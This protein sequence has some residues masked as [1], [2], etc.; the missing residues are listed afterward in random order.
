[1]MAG[2]A[3]FV[4]SKF[5][6]TALRTSLRANVRPA[7]TRRAGQGREGI[8]AGI[9]IDEFQKL[10]CHRILFVFRVLEPLQSGNGLPSITGHG[11]RESS[12]K[13]ARTSIRTRGT[14]SCRRSSIFFCTSSKKSALHNKIRQVLVGK[15]VTR[16]KIGS[17]DRVLYLCVFGKVCHEKSDQLAAAKAYS[18]VLQLDML[19]QEGDQE[20]AKVELILS[21]TLGNELC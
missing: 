2:R 20:Q 14:L 15:V 5:L 8:L 19:Q 3:L 4:G 9:V 13:R 7:Q 10:G 1:M 11:G 18:L 16:S 12:E 17:S 6:S 21:I